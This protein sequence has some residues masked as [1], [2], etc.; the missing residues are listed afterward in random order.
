MSTRYVTQLVAEKHRTRLSA[1]HSLLEY[2][3]ELGI[4]R[5]LEEHEKVCEVCYKILIG[6]LSLEFIFRLLAI[7]AKV[8]RMNFIFWNAKING[9]YFQTHRYQNYF[10]RKLVHLSRSSRKSV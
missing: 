6:S 9:S 2:N 5:I 3:S 4:E 1:R 10:G 8:E 7:G